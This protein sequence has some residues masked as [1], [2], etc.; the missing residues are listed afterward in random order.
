MA[1]VVL[2]ICGS[3][4]GEGQGSGGAEAE[5]P[6]SRSRQPR[7]WHRGKPNRPVRRLQLLSDRPTVQKYCV[8]T[9]LNGWRSATTSIGCPSIARHGRQPITGAIGGL[10]ASISLIRRQDLNSTWTKFLV[11]MRNPRSRDRSHQPHETNNLSHAKPPTTE[12]RGTLHLKRALG[13]R[14]K[15]PETVVGGIEKLETEQKWRIGALGLRT[16]APA[17]AELR[18][19]RGETLQSRWGF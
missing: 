14:R 10:I 9:I 11:Q 18:H 6:C 19:R 17:I 13:G 15:T 7:R 12:S 8:A 3:Y 5:R 1:M 16:C 2:E 4:E